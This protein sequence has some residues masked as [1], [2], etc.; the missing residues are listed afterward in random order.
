[1]ENITKGLWKTDPNEYAREYYKTNCKIFVPCVCGCS[2]KKVLMTKHVKSKR[3]KLNI[4]VIE[5]QE[6][7]EKFYPEIIENLKD[8]F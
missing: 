2:V 8:S 1:M 4:L 7:K 5:N 3:H 6:L